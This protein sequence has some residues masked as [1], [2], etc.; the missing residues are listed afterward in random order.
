MTN[1][2]QTLTAEAKQYYEK[3][4]L[5]RAQIS[6][7]FYPLAKKS[8]LPMNSGNSISF[9][10]LNAFALATTPLAEGQNPNEVPASISEI[11]CTLNEYGNFTKYSSA[12]AKMG[13]DKVVAEFVPA[14]GQNGGESVDAII[15]TIATAGTSV[16]FGGAQTARTSLTA[17]H[18]LTLAMV[19]RGIAQLDTNNSRRFAAGPT[20]EKVGNGKYYLIVHPRVVEDLK[21]DSE[22]KLAVQQNANNDI[23]FSGSIMMI[24]GVEIVQTTCP[25]IVK[26]G[27]GSGGANVYLGL[28]VGQD[29]F[30]APE[31][32]GNNKFELITHDIGSAGTADALNMTG[33]IGWKSTF[34]STVL[35]NAF[36]LR[37]ETGATNG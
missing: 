25:S 19:R 2:L 23:F 12:L 35:N 22:F 4:M 31:I 7:V 33:S 26:T 21:N 1:T 8:P 6:Q 30:A 5:L 37:F 27:E 36:G 14:F 16:I 32:S 10:R 18:V 13:I 20:N 3:E 29:F 11:T 17:S 15:A 9:R 24:D 34:T 28:L